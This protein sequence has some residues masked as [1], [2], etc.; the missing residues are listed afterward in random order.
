MLFSKFS[1]STVSVSDGYSVL[2]V[3]QLKHSV[4]LRGREAGKERILIAGLRHDVNS[5][6]SHKSYNIPMNHRNLH[7]LTFFTA[8]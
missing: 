1:L 7:T 4:K 8:S 2:K 5:S 6:L 3:S